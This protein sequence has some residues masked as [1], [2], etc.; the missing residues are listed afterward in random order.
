M[1]GL[2]CVVVREQRCFNVEVAYENNVYFL[3][4]K[5][6][7]ELVY[8]GRALDLDLYLALENGKWLIAGAVEEGE[9][10]KTI[11]ELTQKGKRLLSEVTIGEYFVGKD[12]EKK[13][14]IAPG[15]VHVLVVAPEYDT[16]GSM[17]SGKRDLLQLRGG[18]VEDVIEGV[19][20]LMKKQRT[21]GTS[22]QISQLSTTKINQLGYQSELDPCWQLMMSPCY[23]IIPDSI[24]LLV[25]PRAIEYMWKTELNLDVPVGKPQRLLKGK[26]DLCIIR[27]KCLLRNEIA[28]VIELK[29]GSKEE[30][31]SAAN[32]AQTMGYFLVANTLFECEKNRP[33]PIGLLTNLNDAWC[34]VWLNPEGKICYAYTNEHNELLDRKTALYYMRKHCNYVN[35]CIQ[36]QALS[37]RNV[38]HVTPRDPHVVFGSIPAGTLEKYSVEYD[39]N[40]ADVLETDEEIRLYEMA[41]RLR[42]TTAF[43][44]PIEFPSFMYS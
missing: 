32:F 27:D 36:D 6:K 33:S 25:F 1:V 43:D 14:V 5:I 22:W 28:M 21:G 11:Q 38:G 34:F 2:C 3:K 9:L 4:Q 10:T 41:K 39:D 30:T 15:Q 42:N 44:V 17:G 23:L 20:S 29:A 26:P 12:G 16:V 7:Q 35:S 40:M 19:G 13:P 37:M 31:L 18:I 24:G 8:P